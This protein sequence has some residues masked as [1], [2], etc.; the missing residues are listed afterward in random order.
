MGLDMQ[1]VRRV[2]MQKRD[3][4]GETG[5]KV[6]VTRK[7]KPVPGISSDKVY[8]IELHAMYWRKANHIHAWFVD[9]VQDGNDDG[10]T[11]PVSPNQ[12]SDLLDRCSKVIEASNLVDE[13]MDEETVDDED[14]PKGIAEQSPRKVIEDA[15]AARHYLPTRKGFFFGSTEYD[16][17]Y[18]EDVVK[19]REWI[20]H[21]FAERDKGAPGDIYY[22][23]SW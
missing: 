9:N 6:K 2:Y 3:R 17:R 4:N 11:Y 22:R 23:S 12:L 16:E 19:T 18:L 15:T 8:S 10:G 13:R 1:A 7:G 20:L 21:M 5:Y 14:D